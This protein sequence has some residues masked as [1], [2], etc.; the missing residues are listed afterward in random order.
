MRVAGKVEP[1]FVEGPSE[2]REAVLA[3]AKLVASGDASVMIR[4][5]Y[6][7]PRRTAKQ[8]DADDELAAL[9]A[10][11]KTLRQQITE[12]TPPRAA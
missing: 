9:T 6:H 7:P 8:P 2:M 3:R 12:A 10:R 1:V 5:E 11:L 4:G